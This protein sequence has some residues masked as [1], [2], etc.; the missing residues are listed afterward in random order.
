MSCSRKLGLGLVLLFGAP[1]IAQA[2]SPPRAAVL[3]PP[4]TDTASD[5]PAQLVQEKKAGPPPA[6][7]EVPQST[8]PG[9]NETPAP[10]AGGTTTPGG[11]QPETRDVETKR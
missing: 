5:Q 2:Q 7:Q 4:I 8:G 3:L 9:A 11:A 6:A 10:S 1:L